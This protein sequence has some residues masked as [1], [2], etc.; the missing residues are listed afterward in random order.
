MPTAVAPADSVVRARIPAELKERAAQM[1]ESMG[2]NLSDFI[3]MSMIRLVDDGRLPFEVAVPS[4][5]N[6]LTCKVLQEVL[7]GEN[8]QAF[9]TPEALF[10]DLGI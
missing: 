2:L 7:A 3:R 5:P 4:T 8:M 1:L 9:D 10:R 6:A